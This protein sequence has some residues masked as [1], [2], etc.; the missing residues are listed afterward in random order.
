M[1]GGPIRCSQEPCGAGPLVIV[2]QMRKLRHR[3]GKQSAKATE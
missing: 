1:D 3:E 2:F